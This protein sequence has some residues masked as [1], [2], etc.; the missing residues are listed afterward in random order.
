MTSFSD[1]KFGPRASRLGGVQATIFFPNGYGASVICG[2]GSYGGDQGLYE[3]AV[4]AGDA[5]NWS[6]CY[7]TPITDDVVGYLSEARVTDLL[8]A[9]EALPARARK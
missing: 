7:S 5:G 8:T 3:L 4:A 9:I 1:L 6:I 2:Q